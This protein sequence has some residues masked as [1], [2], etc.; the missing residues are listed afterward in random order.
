M[1]F[2]NGRFQRHIGL[3]SKN[4]LGCSVPE[5]VHVCFQFSFASVSAGIIYGAYTSRIRF[6]GA[7]VFSMLWVIFVYSVVCHWHWSPT[8]WLKRMKAIDFA[9]G[10]VVHVSAGS[11]GLAAS[12][13]L[14]FLKSKYANLR[15]SDKLGIILGMFSCQPLSC[16]QV[17]TS[18][19]SKPVAIKEK[20]DNIVNTLL[21]TCF[22]YVGWFGFNGGSSG[23]ADAKAGFAFLSTLVCAST[24][25]VVWAIVEKMRLGYTSA[26]SV[27]R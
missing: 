15:F 17:E 5:V 23:S 11:S 8:G 13:F 12:F 21:G 10:D 1:T 25:A 4:D 26:I 3:D 2:S 27:A 19:L 20:R 18:T 7:I 16:I 24:S 9:G 14:G 22:L 6:H